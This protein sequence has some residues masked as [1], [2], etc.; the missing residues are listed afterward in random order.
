MAE[1]MSAMSFGLMQQ[2]P[3]SQVAPQFIHSLTYSLGRFIAVFTCGHLTNA[4]GWIHA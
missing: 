1:R 2:Q 4:N 3:P